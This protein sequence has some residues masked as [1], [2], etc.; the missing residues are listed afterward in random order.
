MGHCVMKNTADSFI[1][2][3]TIGHKKFDAYPTPRDCRV[4]MISGLAMTF[5]G[6]ETKPSRV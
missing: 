4:P 2:M 1:L 3:R 5:E 6:K